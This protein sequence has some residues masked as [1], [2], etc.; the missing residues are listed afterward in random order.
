ML[1]KKYD[2]SDRALVELGR[3]L[4][5]TIKEVGLDPLKYC[6]RDMLYKAY[7]GE[8]PPMTELL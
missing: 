1:T 2:I 7:R 8:R 6:S 4:K 3:R 5:A